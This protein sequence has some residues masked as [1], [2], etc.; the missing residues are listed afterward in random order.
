MLTGKPNKKDGWKETS[1][2][3]IAVKDF[4]YD[5]FKEQRSHMS[6]SQWIHLGQMHLQAAERLSCLLVEK[7]ISSMKS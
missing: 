6:E 7:A 1:Y 5:S 3:E 4:P 2:R